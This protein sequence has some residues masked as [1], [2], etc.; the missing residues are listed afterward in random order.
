MVAAVAALGAY[1]IYSTGIAGKAIEYLK[2]VFETLKA[3]TITAFGA[4]A[5]AM[6]AGDIT[7][8]TDVMWTYLKLQWTKG[9]TFLQGLWADFTNT[10]SD[11]WADSAYAIGDVLI[12]ALSGLASVWNATLAFMAD[13]WTILTSAI[14]KGWNNT[15][16]FLKKGFLRLHELVDIA[17]D[18][19]VQIGGVL[20]NA[21]A[22]VETAWV[23]TVDYL[24]DTWTVFVGQVKSMWNSTVGFLRKAWIK[25]KGLFDEDINVDAEMPKID[26]EIKAADAAEETKKQ[27]A[28]ADRMKRRDARKQ[29]IES[30]RVQM[31][32]GIKQQLDERRKVRSGRDIDA[33]M[34]VIDQETE[35]KNQVVDASRD[36]Q[37]A[38][39]SGW[40]IS[41]KDD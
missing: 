1:F 28:V 33:E 15:I 25:L 20:V 16:G 36:D 22:G 37:F 10:I 7:A 9:T 30:D 12:G 2:G 5:N 24:T 6:K 27:Q 26:K 17:G 19:A 41:S 29:Q 35:A 11:V 3:D 21:L 34:A 13:G 14:Q 4:I 39:R 8:A 38:E 18:V 40:P 23:E 32:E 31:Q